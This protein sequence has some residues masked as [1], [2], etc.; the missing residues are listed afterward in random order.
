MVSE[1]TLSCID[2]CTLENKLPAKLQREQAMSGLLFQIP[3]NERS[4]QPALPEFISL[5]CTPELTISTC[6]KHGLQIQHL[7]CEI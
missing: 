6:T 4:Q 1:I 5:A 2:F 3:P 7:L